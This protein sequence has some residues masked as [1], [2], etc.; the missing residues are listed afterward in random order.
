MK[1][2]FNFSLLLTFVCFLLSCGSGDEPELPDPKPNEPIVE[3]KIPITISLY[4]SGTRATDASYETGDA[5]GVYVVNYTGTTPG[6]LTNTGNHVDNMRFI[7]GAQWVPDQTI[8]WKDNTTHADF[9]AYYPYKTVGNITALPFSVKSDQSTESGYK[10]SEFLWGKTANVIPAESAVGIATKH[11]FSNVIVKLA[12]GTGFTD[13]EIDESTPVVK[14]LNVAS[15]SQINLTTGVAT[16]TGT[17][18]TITM[19]NEGVQFRALV[20]PQ[21]IA[22]DLPIVVVSLGGLDYT[23]KTTTNISF[24][25]NKQ[26]TFTVI[27]NKKAN[28]VNIS[29]GGWETDDID[30]GGNAQ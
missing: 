4:D 28:G 27:L 16:A 2:T 9:Y 14:L 12:A 30:Y 20:V 10:Q 18:G 6:T 17:Q 22:T 21:N 25:A 26:H 7:N 15:Q 11:I 5:V 13:E 19:R 29:I 3:T 24:L 23:L 1:T 8:Y